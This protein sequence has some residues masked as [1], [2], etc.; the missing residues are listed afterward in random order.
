[1]R[2][3]QVSPLFESVPP[4]LYGGTERVVAYLTD[5]LVQ[6]GHDVTLFASADSSTSARLVSPV[7]QSLRLAGVDHLPAAFHLVMLEQVFAEADQFDIIHFHLDHL[8]FPFLRRHPVPHVTTMHG[9]IDLPDL[10]PLFRTYP[11]MPVASIS[12]AQRRPLPWLNWQGTLYHGLPPSLYTSHSTVGDYLLFLGRICDDKGTEEAIEIATRTGHRLVIAAKVD[13]ADQDYFNEVIRHRLDDPLVDFIGE[14]GDGE[15]S[16]LIGGALGVLFPIKWPEPFGMVMIESFAC[17][18][19]VI[20]FPCGSVP[21]IMRDGVSGFVVETVEEAIAAVDRLPELDRISC[22]RYFDERFTA[23]RMA[24]DHVDLYERIL[25]DFPRSHS[26]PH[27]GARRAI[28][29]GNVTT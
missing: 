11:E 22:R 1:M 28:G 19:P 8:H 29:A 21:E 4:K 16:E 12:D 13:R 7:E 10:E 27:N 25:S 9:R 20:A 15:K 17:G 24:T 3:A 6:Q 26:V 23:S 18:T 2:I 5:E 14:V